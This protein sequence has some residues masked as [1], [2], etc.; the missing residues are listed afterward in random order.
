MVRCEHLH[1]EE[2]R[3]M[4]PDVVNT[5][6][7][8]AKAA[9]CPHAV[10]EEARLAIYLNSWVCYCYVTLKAFI[11]RSVARSEAMWPNKAA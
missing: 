9:L 11:L 8:C 10:L 3:Q 7:D 4:L 1:S 5:V 6:E 2:K